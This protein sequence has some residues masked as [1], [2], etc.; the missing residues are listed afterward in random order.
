MGN[1]VSG[2]VFGMFADMESG[3][4]LHLVPDP[5]EIVLEESVEAEPAAPS[6]LPSEPTE[7]R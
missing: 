2:V 3:A 5:V 6:N 7:I 4:L 1:L